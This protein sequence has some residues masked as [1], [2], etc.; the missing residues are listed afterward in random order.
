MDACNICGKKSSVVANIEGAE[1]S[2]CEKCSKM[3]RVL[4]KIKTEST[5]KKTKSPAIIEVKPEAEE[6]IVRN[7]AERIRKAREKSGL[8]QEEFAKELNEKLS[9]VRNAE[10][11]KLVPDIKLAKKIESKYG[12]TLVELQHEEKTQGMTEFKETPTL[13]DLIH[14]KR[15]KK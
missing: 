2:V 6:T 12:I 13:G 10:Q 14:L 9:V 8:T 5:K 4:G 3:G 15:R 7:Y 1:V 11:G